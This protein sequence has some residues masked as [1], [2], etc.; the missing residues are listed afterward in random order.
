MITSDVSV[1]HGPKIYIFWS[2]INVKDMLKTYP[3]D[4]SFLTT[5]TA[6]PLPTTCEFHHWLWGLCILWQKWWSFSHLWCHELAA[7]PG[8][9]YQGPQSWCG[10]WS[11]TDRSC[12]YTEWGCFVLELWYK[13]SKSHTHKSQRG[14]KVLENRLICLT[15]CEALAISFFIYCLCCI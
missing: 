12:A 11:C 5:G 8:W 10:G 2:N 3:L 1:N 14:S 4:L 13:K 7:K 15:T 9:V 6:C